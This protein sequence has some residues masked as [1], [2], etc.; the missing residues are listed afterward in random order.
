MSVKYF[1]AQ[2]FVP[3]VMITYRPTTPPRLKLGPH[4]LI[5]LRFLSKKDETV[6]LA[7][8]LNL[9]SPKPA[10]K[11]SLLDNLTKG[12]AHEQYSQ[13][14]FYDLPIKSLA[15]TKY[16][17]TLLLNLQMIHNNVDIVSLSE[18]DLKSHIRK[19]TKQSDFIH[20]YNC[21]SHCNRLSFDIL[22]LILLNKNLK[23]Y[24]FITSDDV[25]FKILLMK[26]YYDLKQPLKIIK[27]LKENL[28]LYLDL[29]KQ[30]KLSPFYERI[31]WKFNFQ[32]IKQ[33]DEV[34]YIKLLD[35]AKSS[36]LIW[37]SSNQF[38]P[39]LIETILSQKN[40]TQP[41]KS[42]FKILSSDFITSNMT[43]TILSNFKKISIKF[44][45]HDLQSIDSSFI[46]TLQDL[47]N[48]ISDQKDDQLKLL[49]KEL[50][51]I[52]LS[53]E[54]QELKKDKLG[55]DVKWDENPITS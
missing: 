6:I 22:S 21:L 11:P 28:S 48:V 17:D 40:L 45:L 43:P 51:L 41:Q 2:Q 1:F 49:M 29:I 16:V 8:A 33:F 20:T 13:R 47:V 27:D 9:L 4:L 53:A 15:H 19:L 14:K 10:Y 26:K 35:S 54:V 38:N 32:Y 50:Q 42:F 55:V 12:P 52:A 3:N 7:D 31:I 34:H 30:N 37:E 18:L 25:R 36:I 5:L 23:D 44:K 39:N 24:S 46:S